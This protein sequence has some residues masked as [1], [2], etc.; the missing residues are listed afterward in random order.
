MDQSGGAGNPKGKED[1]RM[2]GGNAR[3]PLVNGTPVLLLLSR[4][5][6]SSFVTCW[7]N[8][9]AMALLLLFSFFFQKKKN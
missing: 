6:G 4:T 9:S 2:L 8:P 5:P 7:I 1:G 3:V